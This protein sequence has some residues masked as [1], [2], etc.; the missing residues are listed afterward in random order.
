MIDRALSRF[1][2]RIAL[3]VEVP[4][5]SLAVLR[6]IVGLYLLLFDTP[7][8]SW[9]DRSP[10]AFFNPPIPSLSYIVGGFPPKPF[11]L[12][13]DLVALT[14]LCSMTI[15][16]RTRTSTLILLVTRVV[17]TNFEYSFGKI[18]HEILLIVLLSCMLIA[19]WG[20]PRQRRYDRPSDAAGNDTASLRT[21][22]ANSILAL[23]LAFGFLT[24]GI[25]KLQN[26]VNAD[27]S[28]SGILSWYYPN[29][30]TLGR[31]HLLAGLVPG[32]P[33]VLLKIGDWAAALLE[34]SAFIALI[35]GRLSWRIF[36]ILASIFH[37]VN[38]LVLNIDFTTQALIYLVF[39]DLS[40]LRAKFIRFRSAGVCAV[41]AIALWHVVTRLG[42]R[43]ASTV[44]INNRRTR[45]IGML[46]VGLVVGVFVIGMMVRDLR[47]IGSRADDRDGVAPAGS[48]LNG[49]ET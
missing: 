39:A 3:T 29:L 48:E 16:Y 47:T 19:D 45:D 20:R 43:G 33:R 23:A 11:F 15:G 42:G 6:W 36:L 9:I 38:I 4:D 46:Y 28:S 2:D 25:P 44:F 10:T 34:V 18:D 5:T 41:F 24:A 30:F 21:V 1:W 7:Y 22:Q 17:G 12:I 14:A 32:V 8:Y 31:S 35:G 27:L 26:W 49:G 13:L 40:R 37:I